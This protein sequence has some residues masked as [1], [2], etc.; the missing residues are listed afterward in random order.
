MKM[1]TRAII[2]TCSSVLLLQAHAIAQSFGQLKSA[3]IEAQSAKR[4]EEADNFW[5][6]AMESCQDKSGPRYIQSLGGLAKSLTEQGK[7]AEAE[8]LYKIVL[9]NSKP[10]SSTEDLRLVLK[11]Y[12]SLL[13]LAKRTEDANKLEKDYSLANDESNKIKEPSQEELAANA[14]KEAQEKRIKLLQE[15]QQALADGNRGLNGKQLTL[16]EQSG[17]KALK[18]AEEAGEASYTIPALKLL[19][20][21]Y[22]AQ[23][24]T[25]QAEA[26]AKRCAEMNKTKYGT[27]SRQYADALNSHAEILRKLNRRTEAIA[28]E[29]RVDDIKSKLNASSSAS[30]QGSSAGVDNSAAIAGTK[31]GSL[32]KRAGAAQNINNSVRDLGD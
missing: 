18:L 13:R 5:R 17:Q 2:L 24:K 12:A 32:Y 28:E 30:S 4:Y 8:S 25:A 31:G 9:E 19:T 11:D 14:K 20:L 22:D 21:V 6:K 10:E 15:A 1:T 26:M 23:N 7:T 16:A 3:A 27:V 29:G